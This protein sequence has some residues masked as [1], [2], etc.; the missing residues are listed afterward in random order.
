MLLILD[1]VERINMFTVTDHTG[2][3]TTACKQVCRCFYYCRVQSTDYVAGMWALAPPE[4]ISTIYLTTVVIA[5]VGL[6]CMATDLP[7]E[8]SK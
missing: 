4:Y 3:C 6:K 2:A 8:V 1:V 7:T 5:L